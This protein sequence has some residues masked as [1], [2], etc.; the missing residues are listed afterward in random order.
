MRNK[1]R[2]NSLQI[3]QANNNKLIGPFGEWLIKI[4]FDL[5]I[6]SLSVD[7]EDALKYA[8][9]ELINDVDFGWDNLIGVRP[10]LFILSNFALDLWWYMAQ[11]SQNK[12]M[13]WSCINCT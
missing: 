12:L 2:W 10:I 1:H 5:R 9:L 7:T 8:P 11:E 13:M 4:I 3:D 6:N